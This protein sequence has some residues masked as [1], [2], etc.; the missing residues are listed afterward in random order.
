MDGEK[1]RN[2]SFRSVSNNGGVGFC[3][4]LVSLKVLFGILRMQF[5]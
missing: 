3:D 5:D 2:L 1:G 4:L